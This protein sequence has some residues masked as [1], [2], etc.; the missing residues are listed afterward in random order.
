MDKMKQLLIGIA[1]AFVCALIAVV[2]ALWVVERD[3]HQ[4][5]LS[6]EREERARAEMLEKYRQEEEQVRAATQKLANERWQEITSTWKAYDDEPKKNR[7][8]ERLG[9]AL[10]DATTMVN[11]SPRHIRVAL[12]NANRAAFRKRMAPFVQPETTAIGDEYQVLVP[13]PDAAK[14]LLWGSSWADG[15]AADLR[16]MGFTKIACPSEKKEWKLLRS[17]HTR[18]TDGTIRCAPVLGASSSSCAWAWGALSLQPLA[19]PRRGR[20]CPVAR[21][22]PAS[23]VL[24]SGRSG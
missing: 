2:I 23:E 3:R 14:C 20:R 22:P 13:S 24:G 11:E 9:A 10:A 8:K 12:T 15:S 6:A 1:G 18:E 5:Q 16:T 7:T 17:P 4:R 21:P 19:V